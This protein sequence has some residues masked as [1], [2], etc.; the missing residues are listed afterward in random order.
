ML[1]VSLVVRV[2][3]VLVL[4]RLRSRVLAEPVG[5]VGVV[6]GVGGVVV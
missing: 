1:D 5:W 3:V 4:L 6:E 2:L